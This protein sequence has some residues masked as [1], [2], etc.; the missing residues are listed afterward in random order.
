[1]FL[2]LVSLGDIGV[3][4][5][6][7]RCLRVNGLGKAA[8][9]DLDLGAYYQYVEFSVWQGSHEE[10]MIRSKNALE[11]RKQL[12]PNGHHNIADLLSHIGHVQHRQTKHYSET[13]RLFPNGDLVISVVNWDICVISF[14][15]ANA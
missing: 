8:M 6:E 5:R 12:F 15:R 13:L 11:M 10:V 3:N 2:A 7:M 14:Q 4:E 9:E 1:M